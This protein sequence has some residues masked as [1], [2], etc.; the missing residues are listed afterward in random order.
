MESMTI[1]W[2]YEVRLLP[3]LL[4]FT[5]YSG[6]Q[7]LRRLTTVAYTPSYFAIFP[8]SLLERQLGEYFGESINGY[9]S[10]EDGRVSDRGLFVK[11]LLS[12]VLTFVIVPVIVGFLV[13][14]LL[15]REEFVG[16]LFLL[17]GFE[18]LRCSKATYDLSQFRDNWRSGLLFA[19]FYLFYLIF[20]WLCLRIGYRFAIP[21][22]ESGNYA[23]LFEA[24]E[25]QFAP[26]VLVGG[27]VG[28]IGGLFVHYLLNKDTLKP[29]WHMPSTE[30]SETPEDE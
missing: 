10:L 27:G 8:L 23:G 1:W 21:F 22:T 17:V 16:F 5:S 6:I 30:N 28:V 11:S 18:F 26:V 14:F 13:A 20:L 7:A 15:T 29:S 25:S 4:A 2:Q 24:L 19:G 12:V 3:I 9:I